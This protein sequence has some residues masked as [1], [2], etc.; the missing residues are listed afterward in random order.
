MFLLSFSLRFS[1]HLLFIPRSFF[2]VFF[3][4]SFSLCMKCVCLTHRWKRWM[5]STRSRV[6]AWTEALINP[7]LIFQGTHFFFPVFVCQQR[8]RENM[9]PVEAGKQRGNREEV[10]EWEK[11][12]TFTRNRDI[13]VTVSFSCLEV[14]TCIVRCMVV[15]SIIWVFTWHWK[16]QTSCRLQS[17]SF[18]HPTDSFTRL[19]WDIHSLYCCLTSGSSREPLITLYFYFFFFPVYD[20]LLLKQTT[21]LSS[22]R[23]C[24]S[25][26]IS[27]LF[28]TFIRVV[29]LAFW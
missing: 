10:Y 4:G 25:P 14:V 8:H 23:D 16:W 2:R 9:S 29:F 7:K 12:Q 11:Q 22:W 5:N 24:L 17:V 13:Y 6:T 28:Q 19:R 15:T 21:D 27:C 26:W 18:R 3:L 1:L 20:H